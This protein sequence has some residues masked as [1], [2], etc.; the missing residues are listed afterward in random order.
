MANKVIKILFAFMCIAPLLFACASDPKP[1]AIDGGIY[2]SSDLNP[3]NNKRPSPVVLRI[4][5]LRGKDKFNNTDFFS[6]YDNAE[7]VLAKELVN[8]EEKELLPGARYQYE[9]DLDP[10]TM[11]VGVIAAFRDIDNAQWRSID[12]VPEKKFFDLIDK[13]VVEISVNKL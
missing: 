9:V 8:M 11:F 6:L 4:Y 12:Q 1:R 5:Q 10:E 7:A 13:P 3:D 2:T